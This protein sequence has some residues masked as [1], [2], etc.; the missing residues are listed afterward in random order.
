M[1]TPIFPAAFAAILLL[2]ACA[3]EPKFTKARGEMTKREKDSVIAESGLP[4]ASVVKKGMS[5]ADAEARRAAMYDSIA[6]Q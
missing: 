1:R 3:E 6:G 4:G 2:A 5:I